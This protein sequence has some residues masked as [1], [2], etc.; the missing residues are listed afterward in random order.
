MPGISI[1]T[2]PLEYF[3]PAAHSCKAAWMAAS[4]GTWRTGRQRLGWKV[5][6]CN[7]STGK[8]KAGGRWGVQGQHPLFK[9]S[10]AGYMRPC[11]REQ[12]RKPSDK[13]LLSPMTDSKQQDAPI[14]ADHLGQ[15]LAFQCHFLNSLWIFTLAEVNDLAPSWFMPKAPLFLTHVDDHNVKLHPTLAL[16]QP[17]HYPGKEESSQMRNVSTT[18]LSKGQALRL[19][20]HK[21]ERALLG[22][23]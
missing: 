2:S 16:F 4:G 22:K 7:P 20:I 11:L 1:P 23:K 13:T 17:P 19:A 8:A 12:N 10:H 21:L 9:Q 5:H 14:E 6:V 15:L 3:K 18:V